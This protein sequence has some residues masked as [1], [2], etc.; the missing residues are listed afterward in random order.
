MRFCVLSPGATPP[1]DAATVD[2]IVPQAHGG[3]TVRWNL[4]LLC[5]TCNQKK[6]DEY[7]R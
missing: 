2:H 1:P 3:K 5:Y 6:A 7:A 4:Q